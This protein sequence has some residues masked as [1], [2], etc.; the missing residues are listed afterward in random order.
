MGT[1]RGRGE[2]SVFF[3][4]RRQRWVALASYWQD[5][6]F[7]RKWV[8]ALTRQEAQRRL[9]AVLAGLDR[10]LAPAPE[11]QT[12]GQFLRDWLEQTARPT[13][14]PRTYVRY[15]EL[16]TL[17]AI[18][19]LDKRPLARLAPQDLQALYRRKLDEGLSPRTVGHIHRVLHRALQDALRWGWTA[20]NVCAVVRPPKVARAEPR[21][22]SPEEARRL[23]DAARGDP[24][25]ALW[26]LALTTGVRQG[27]LL[28]LKW[29]DIDLDG[30]RLH[31]RRTAYR[32]RGRGWVEA[33]PKS[34]TARRSVALTPLA[35]DALRRHKARQRAQRLRAGP[36]WEDRDLVFANAVGGYLEPQNLLRRAFWPLL[37]KAGLSRLRFHDLRH[38]AATL[39]LAQGVHPKV[40]QELLGHSS[41]SLTLDTYSHTVPDL[42]A[43]AAARLERLLGA[44]C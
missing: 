25:E 8:S 42:Q 19:A 38:S 21:V 32:L 41:I 44:N 1:R 5:G 15:R 14:R 40:V 7:R 17:H 31:V 13:V 22:L 39:L 30:G 4:A 27:E 33:E 24:L 6:R 9:R 36:L 34:Q 28:G 29:S 16:L 43:E 37:Q 2:G 20:R 10:G 26:V 18:P 35:V 11:R 12:V 3:D 23:L